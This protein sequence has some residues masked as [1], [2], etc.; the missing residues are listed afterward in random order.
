MHRC[1]RLVCFAVLA[2]AMSVPLAAPAQKQEADKPDKEFTPGPMT[3]LDQEPQVEPAFASYLDWKRIARCYADLDAAG[4]TD[5]A[6]ALAEGERIYLR[7]HRGVS[8]ERLLDDAVQLAIRARDK[9]TL[10]RIA[11]AAKGSGNTALTERL[12]AAEK[13]MTTSRSLLA[14]FKVSVEDM[15][16]LQAEQAKRFVEDVERARLLQDKVQLKSLKELL[17]GNGEDPLAE[18]FRAPLAKMLSSAETAIPAAPDAESEQLRETLKKLGANSRATSFS[19]LGRYSTTPS[20]GININGENIRTYT[21][22][23]RGGANSADGEEAYRWG[24]KEARDNKKFATAGAA[25]QYVRI[26]RTD[27]RMLF[28]YTNATRGGGDWIAIQ[29]RED[30]QA[31][32]RLRNG[33]T[34]HV[35]YGHWHYTTFHV[36]GGRVILQWGPD[37]SQPLPNN[38]GITWGLHIRQN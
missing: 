27:Y 38:Q 22:H 16:L 9:Q 19:W 26:R 4:L 8:A 23:Y 35:P 36:N 7:K 20:T 32:Y 6:L 10:D 37:G 25:Q 24:S 29:H 18:A 13:L 21:V 33:T 30:G 1:G 15:S 14:D 5:C 12:S 2:G 34:G 28:G 31:F 3:E 11:R 17:T